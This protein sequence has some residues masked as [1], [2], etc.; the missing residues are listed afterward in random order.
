MYSRRHLGF[1]AL[2]QGCPKTYTSLFQQQLWLLTELPS[3]FAAKH[4]TP[5]PVVSAELIHVVPNG[6]PSITCND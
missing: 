3:M 6:I 5:S 2:Q 1:H 4:A